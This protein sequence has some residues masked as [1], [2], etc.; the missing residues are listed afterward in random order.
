MT[1]I[2]SLSSHLSKTIPTK[3]INIHQFL[4]LIVI[5]LVLATK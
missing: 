1:I 4:E 5:D 2:L 3:S